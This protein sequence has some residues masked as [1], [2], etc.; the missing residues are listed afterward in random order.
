MPVLKP[1]GIIPHG[2]GPT[3][4]ISIVIEPAS[5]EKWNIEYS[6]PFNFPFERQVN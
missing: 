3:I 6:I 1:A 4:Y 5:P 2:S